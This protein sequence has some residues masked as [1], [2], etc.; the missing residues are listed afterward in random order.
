MYTVNSCNG[1]N[2]FLR[3]RTLRYLTKAIESLLGSVEG[4]Y[5]HIYNMIYISFSQSTNF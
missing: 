2:L 1:S 3:L 5:T 4:L